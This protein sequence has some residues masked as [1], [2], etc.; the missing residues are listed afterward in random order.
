M[1]TKSRQHTLKN[2]TS[3]FPFLTDEPIFESPCVSSEIIHVEL[4][5]DRDAGMRQ[6]PRGWPRGGQ[7]PDPPDSTKVEIFSI[8][9]FFII[10][11]MAVQTSG[12]PE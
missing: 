11:I 1:E 3:S 6:K 10:T 9:V 4:C 5:L 12:C 2:S 8:Y 7:V